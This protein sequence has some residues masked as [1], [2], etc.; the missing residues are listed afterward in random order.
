MR[1]HRS[2]VVPLSSLLAAVAMLAAPIVGAEPSKEL[3]A[4]LDR[5]LDAVPVRDECLAFKVSGIFLRAGDR[6]KPLTDRI[7]VEYEYGKP[8]PRAACAL[9]TGTVNQLL[10]KITDSA[11]YAWQTDGDWINLVPR[12][13]LADPSYIMNQRIPG[14]IVLSLDASRMSSVSDWLR[15]H[16]ISM[17]VEGSILSRADRVAAPRHDDIVLTDPTLR[18]YF[19]AWETLYG[20]DRWSVRVKTT[21]DPGGKSLPRITLITSAYAS[22]PQRSTTPGAK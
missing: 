2:L 16:G 20:Y 6:A 12:A 5:K 11:G 13:K 17:A 10:G 14:R 18:E 3:Q 9:P 21:P 1:R 19:N 8:A 4:L 7:A 15:A 22:R